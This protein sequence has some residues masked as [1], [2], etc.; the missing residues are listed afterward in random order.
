MLPCFWDEQ[1]P[2]PM[3]WIGPVSVTSPLLQLQLRMGWIHVTT[4]VAHPESANVLLCRKSKLCT[5]DAVLLA[6]DS[7]WADGSLHVRRW[8]SKLLLQRKRHSMLRRGMFLMVDKRQQEAVFEGKVSQRHQVAT[9]EK[10]SVGSVSKVPISIRGVASPGRH[11][12]FQGSLTTPIACFHGS[13][14]NHSAFSLQQLF[15]PSFLCTSQTRIHYRVRISPS[16]FL[17]SSAP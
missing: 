7:P 2:W 4:S 13:S 16:Y 14:A 11:L 3:I 15:L 1:C 9:D 8:G 17:S 6:A 12:L 5:V 10:E